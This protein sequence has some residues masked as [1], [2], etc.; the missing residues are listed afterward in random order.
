MDTKA[1]LRFCKKCKNESFDKQLGTICSLTNE[2]PT[3]ETTCPNY[4]NNFFEIY[5]FLTIPFTIVIFLIVIG[6]YVLS[7]IAG[8]LTIIIII[9][10]KKE[11]IKSIKKKGE[12]QA[13]RE[14]HKEK[15]NNI[16]IPT[17]NKSRAELID[18]YGNPSKEFS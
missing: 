13:G 12:R 5:G 8:V 9:G 17:Y 2:L 11:H 1:Q 6:W 15:I 3:F 18:K 14:R 7:A 4:K 10:T 16:I